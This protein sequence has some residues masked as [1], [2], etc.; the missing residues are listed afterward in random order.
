M[1]VRGG[2]WTQWHW[3]AGK[4]ALA[5]RE[6]V[7]LVDVEFAATGPVKIDLNEILKFAFAASRQRRLHS[8]SV[9]GGRFAQDT[10]TRIAVPNL[11]FWWDQRA[12]RLLDHA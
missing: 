6:V 5:R 12:S 1:R 2:G 9:H 3:M 4:C 7:S 10:A 11:P 8:R